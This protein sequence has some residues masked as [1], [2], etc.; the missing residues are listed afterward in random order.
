MRVMPNGSFRRNGDLV[1]FEWD[2]FEFLVAEVDGEWRFME[3]K[4]VEVRHRGDR[5]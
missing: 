1:Q 5:V 3:E 2:G 4:A